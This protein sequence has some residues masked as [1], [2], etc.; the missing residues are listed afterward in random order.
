MKEVD[1]LKNFH[2]KEKEQLDANF[3]K[4][5][6]IQGANVNAINRIVRILYSQPR[7]EPPSLCIQL[8]FTFVVSLGGQRT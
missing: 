4:V 2:G 6:I 8:L 5:S 3:Q 1:E 7:L